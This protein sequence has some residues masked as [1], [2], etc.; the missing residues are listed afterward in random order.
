MPSASDTAL[1]PSCV[2]SRRW[3]LR[4]DVPEIMNQ[5]AALAF[6]TALDTAPDTAPGT[7]PHFTSALLRLLA[8]LHGE[9]PASA[10]Q[11]EL[12]DPPAPSSSLTAEERVAAA[13]QARLI[14][15]HGPLTPGSKLEQVFER[16]A[17]ADDLYK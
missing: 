3:F 4:S 9:I 11:G 5:A 14:S 13:L 2:A 10:L 16:C 12:P 15:Q 6:I 1:H 17:E 8:H 7:V